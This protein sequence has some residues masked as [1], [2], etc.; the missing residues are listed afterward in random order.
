MKMYYN[1]FCSTAAAN[2]ILSDISG[3]AAQVEVRSP[4]LDYRMVEFA[5]KLPHHY[6]VR[7]IFTS[8][9]NK[10]LPKRYYAKYVANRLAWSRKKGL[11]YNMPFSLYI[12]NGSEKL[13]SASYDAIDRAGL[14]SKKSRE[15]LERYATSILIG[16][17]PSPSDS[18]IMMS[19]F[20]LG[21]WLMMNE[22]CVV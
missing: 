4:Y 7:N 1:I 15:A 20:L 17:K 18:R 6:K 19:S 10:Y 13:F 5:A 11:S 3:L 9:S 16:N 22:G 12:K 2:Y 8:G 21:R 14:K